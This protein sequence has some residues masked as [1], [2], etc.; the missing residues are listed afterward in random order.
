MINRFPEGR[1]FWSSYLRWYRYNLWA[2]WFFLPI[3]IGLFIGLNQSNYSDLYETISK[4]QSYFIYG[5]FDRVGFRRS[6]RV[7]IYTKNDTVEA[8]CGFLHYGGDSCIGDDIYKNNNVYKIEISNYKG[9]KYILGISS[10][11]G[12]EILPKD[13]SIDRARS[14]SI[15]ARS[16]GYP[17]QA[18]KGLI[19][20]L[21]FFSV[22]RY[23]I[24][25]APRR[26]KKKLELKN[27][28]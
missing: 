27:D 2:N 4:S 20:A 25:I 6:R 14:Q 16:I 13:K 24:Y 3:L 19:I 28:Q 7:E 21:L 26:R 11:D 1:S 18:V 23:F 9:K 12:K 15:Y 10:M 8:W 22:P 5:K 17:W